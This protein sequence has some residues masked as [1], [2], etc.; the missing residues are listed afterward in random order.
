MLWMREEE[1]LARD[2]YL[3]LN[4]TWQAIEFKNIARSEQRHFDALG[5]RISQYRQS[6]SAQPAV[7]QFS[8]PELQG[9]YYTLLNMG[10]TSYLDALR[11]GAT[12][13]DLDIRDLLAAIEETSNSDLKQTYSSLM[14]GSKNHMRA[15]VSRLEAAGA[16]YEPQY[17]DPVLFDAIVGR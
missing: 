4:Q 14:E 9:L 16:S 5:A 10:S 7:G 12:I 2:V 3:G 17:I 15:F 8:D 11:V 13:E 1:K 6:D